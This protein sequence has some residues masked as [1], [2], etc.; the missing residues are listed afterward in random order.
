MYLKLYSTG[1][2]WSTEHAGTLNTLNKLN[3]LEHT[4]HAGTLLDFELCS[5][6]HLCQPY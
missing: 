6:W 2:H 5:V 4:E 3:T 1:T